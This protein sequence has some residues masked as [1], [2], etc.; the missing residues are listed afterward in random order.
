MSEQELLTDLLNSEKALVKDYIGNYT[1]TACP[2]LRTLLLN[3]M[4]ECSEDQFSVFEQMQQRNMYKTKKA[5][6]RQLSRICLSSNS[7]PGKERKLSLNQKTM[8]RMV[9]RSIVLILQ[10]LSSE[11]QFLLQC[12]LDGLAY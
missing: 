4:T 11:K 12:F 5:Q 8:L 6:P 10:A 7:R 3:C 2:K 9:L 1:E